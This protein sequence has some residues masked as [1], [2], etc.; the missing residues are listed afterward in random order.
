MMY[1][2]GILRN[3]FVMIQILK[4]DIRRISSFSLMFSQKTHHRRS[5]H[6]TPKAYVMDLQRKSATY[7]R[8]SFF[9]KI[10]DLNRTTDRITISATRMASVSHV[11]VRLRATKPISSKTGKPKTMAQRF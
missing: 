7:W 4:D 1:A 10:Y 9:L 11:H 6:H 8:R 5:L 2:C 3:H